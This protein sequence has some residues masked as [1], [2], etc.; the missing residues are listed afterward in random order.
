MAT[1]PF[2]IPDIRRGRDITPD[3]LAEVAGT[4]LDKGVVLDELPPAEE[5]HAKLAEVTP[6]AFQR[7]RRPLAAHNS[8]P[9]RP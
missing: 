9:M 6:G 3:V 5:Q 2:I 4:D 1:L 7:L 8:P